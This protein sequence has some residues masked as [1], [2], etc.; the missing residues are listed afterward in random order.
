MVV[1]DG[2]ASVSLSQASLT[3]LSS[4]KNNA[5]NEGDDFYPDPDIPS[6][7]L[8]GARMHGDMLHI[9]EVLFSSTTD[10]QT[11]QDWAICSFETSIIRKLRQTRA[12][13]SFP[14]SP[15]QGEAQRTVSSIAYS[16]VNQSALVITASRGIVK[17]TM[18]T[19][20]SFYRAEGE[21]RFIEVLAIRL[22]QTLGQST[23]KCGFIFQIWLTTFRIG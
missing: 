6:G 15:S 7:P 5:T 4:H 13:N 21:K 9:G 2:T 1:S 17:G 23:T 19:T 20:P 3:D 8:T 12:L 11:E 10:G 22:E 16:M 18:S 14:V